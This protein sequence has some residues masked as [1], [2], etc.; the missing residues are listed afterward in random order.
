MGSLREDQYTFLSNLAELFVE[1]QMFQAKVVQ[2]SKHTFY[3][4]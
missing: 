1:G 3:V 4:Q 2:K